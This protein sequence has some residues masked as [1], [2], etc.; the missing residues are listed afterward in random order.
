MNIPNS[1]SFTQHAAAFKRSG[2]TYLVYSSYPNGAPVDNVKRKDAKDAIQSN[3]PGTQI[4]EHHLVFGRV[5]V[6]GRDTGAVVYPISDSDARAI[7]NTIKANKNDPF[8]TREDIDN[9]IIPAIIQKDMAK[10]GSN[11]V[12]YDISRGRTLT[13]NEVSSLSR[14]NGQSPQQ[15][16]TT[17]RGKALLTTDP[18]ATESD[19]PSTAAT[20]EVASGKLP[21]A[22]KGAKP[23]SPTPAAI[24]PPYA[25]Q[26]S[27]TSGA[28]PFAAP[29]G[30]TAVHQQ[31]ASSLLPFNVSAPKPPGQPVAV[32]AQGTNATI[33]FQ[34]TGESNDYMQPRYPAP[35]FMPLAPGQHAPPFP[36]V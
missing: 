32:P 21:P 36:E 1:S 8:R 30:A 5:K 28:N 6:S 15:A 29:T 22:V 13:P 34:N 7:D 35:Y 18:T 2:A 27:V 17:S 20:T 11:I 24:A 16:I 9:K 3:S 33:D 12:I 25:L 14:S 31:K 4:D 10:G 23:A 19:P 26:G